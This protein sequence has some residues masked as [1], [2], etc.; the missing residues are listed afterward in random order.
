MISGGNSSSLYLLSND[1]VSTLPHGITNLRI[2][3]AFFTGESSLGTKFSAMY[4]NVF[5]MHAQIIE[6]K[7]KPSY[8]IGKIDVNAF[9]NVPTFVD[10]GKRVKGILAIGR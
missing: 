2:G 10:K 5:R 6:L 8:P 1:S 7:E 4:G 3:D 9:G